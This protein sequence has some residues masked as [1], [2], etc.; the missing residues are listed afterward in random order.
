LPHFVFFKEKKLK[1]TREEG[2][3]VEGE[4]KRQGKKEIELDDAS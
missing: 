4:T 3:E 1:T 2:K